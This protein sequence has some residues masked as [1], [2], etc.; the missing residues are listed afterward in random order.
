[1]VGRLEK[2]LTLVVDMCAGQMRRPKIP[3][4]TIFTCRQELRERLYNTAK[5]L[6][7]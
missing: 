4:T 1:M 7:V 2:A 6:K 3:E 5:C